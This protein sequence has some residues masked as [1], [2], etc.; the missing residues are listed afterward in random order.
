MKVVVRIPEREDYEF[1]GPMR[2]LDV[3]Q[4]LDF[5]PEEVIVIRRDELLTRNEVVED[6]DEIEVRPAVSGG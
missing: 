1:K 4:K 3:V 6:T 2:V 5:L